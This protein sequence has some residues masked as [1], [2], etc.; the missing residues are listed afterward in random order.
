MTGA[1][2]MD[3]SSLT[4]E[5]QTLGKEV[6]IRVVNT[7]LATL[8]PLR[9]YANGVVN[10]GS[11]AI[12]NKVLVLFDSVPTENPVSA[13][14][15]YGFGVNAGTLRY[16]TPQ[17][18]HAHR[19]Y[20]AS[21]NAYTITNTGGANGSDARFK[22]ELRPIEH[23]LQKISQ[24]QGK[25]FKMYDNT[26]REMGF[27]AQE[28]LPIVP[29]VVWI[30]ESDERYHFLKY[31]KLTA[32]LCEGIKELLGKVTALEAKVAALEAIPS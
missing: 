3:G 10:V 15:F 32:L 31:D 11:A 8:T 24:L 12:N 5:S 23:A 13:A 4:M 26:D 20:C 7:S 19:F 2:T 6:N 17:T 28:V 18:T 29:E 1:L 9:C 14:S 27:V 16:Q 25:T 21:T 30:D 22:S